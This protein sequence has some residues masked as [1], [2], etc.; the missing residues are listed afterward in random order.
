MHVA[1]GESVFKLTQKDMEAY[2]QH[3]EQSGCM[4]E[5]VQCYRRYLE[6]MTA[7]E[8]RNGISCRSF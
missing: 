2:L 6:F 4:P 5:T 7:A 1:S 8:H 3:L